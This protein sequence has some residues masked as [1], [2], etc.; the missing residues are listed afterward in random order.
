MA[1]IT[2]PKI[3]LDCDVIIHFV[4]G[5]QQLLLPKIFPGQFVIIDKV[6]QEL[7]KRKS[8]LQELSN[9]LSW[10]KI[11]IL[12]MPKEVNVIKEY[13]F[14]K[15]TKGDGEAACMAV[16]KYSKDYIA[17]SNLSDI[18]KYCEDNEIV[19][20]TTMDLLLEA[21]NNG[22]INEA[23]CDLFIYEVKSKGSILINGVDT[24]KAYKELK[25][26]KIA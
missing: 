26:K 3:L 21:Y 4:K 18:K 14:L 7:E 9:F 25:E 15:K 22:L 5:G 19:Y 8:G 20:L 10:C 17:S 23:D 2:K 12:P 1:K 13:A 16:A 11:D 6:L 24:I